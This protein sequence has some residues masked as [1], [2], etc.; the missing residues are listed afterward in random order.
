MKAF[1]G[2]LKVLED[3]VARLP[4]ALLTDVA[5]ILVN[6]SPDVTGAYVLSH[7][8][9]QS[10]AVGR[11]ISSHGRPEAPNTHKE[12]ARAGLYAQAAAI[13]PTTT[14]VWVG[15]NAPHSNKVEFGWPEYGKDGYAVYA[16]L[17]QQWPALIVTAKSQVGLK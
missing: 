2:R 7:S 16:L 11:R 9:G 14:R 8:I 6:K 15:N 3:K 17:T 4:T 5:D 1:L 12:E 10:G 13:P